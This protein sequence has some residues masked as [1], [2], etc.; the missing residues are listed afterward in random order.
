[1][2]QRLCLRRR[3]S[4]STLSNKRRISK[5]PG[6]KLVYL[7]QKKA[8]K[9]PRCGDTGVKLQVPVLA[10]GSV[11]FVAVLDFNE[12]IVSQ[13]RWIDHWWLFVNKFVSKICWI[14]LFQGIKP[15][16][17]SA[18]K[19]MPKRHKR[20]S[21]AY[22]GNLCAAAVRERSVDFVCF[23][24]RWLNWVSVV[25]DGVLFPRHLLGSFGLSWSRSKRSS[26][27]CWRPNKPL[28]R[29]PLLPLPE[30]KRRR[31]RPPNERPRLELG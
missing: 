18:L 26:C 13:L 9:I 7:Y 21:R 12:A 19:N 2:V 28:R 22:G 1:M 17:P 14:P 6:G 25:S 16:R 31:R 11:S 10:S 4:Y 27:V 24:G 30:A 8:A 20:V 5:T 23:D 15:A 29:R 3:M